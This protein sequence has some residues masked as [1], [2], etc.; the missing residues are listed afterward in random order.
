MDT[1]STQTIF[2]GAVV[3][4]NN[5][6]APASF[7]K[8]FFCPSDCCGFH[9]KLIYIVQFV[10]DYTISCVIR[11][12]GSSFQLGGGGGLKARTEDPR[13]FLNLESLKCHFL[14]FGEDLT[15]F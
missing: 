1:S 3:V 10:P 5:F 8:Q 6:F 12:V 13:K 7:C 4:A 2:F 14:D 9:Y 11:A 15:Q